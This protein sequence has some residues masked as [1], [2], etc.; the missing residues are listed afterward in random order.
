MNKPQPKLLKA[1]I[2]KDLMVYKDEFWLGMAMF[3]LSGRPV[4]RYPDSEVHPADLRTFTRTLS[5]REEDYF[6]DIQ[7]V[8]SD[9][10]VAL[11]ESFLL[12]AARFYNP[13][14]FPTI[15]TIECPVLR[16]LG[17]D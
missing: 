9:A 3:A 6:K 17:G 4:E 15:Q 16:M 2:H 12:S 5:A 13:E 10:I 1:R 14:K 11:I 7:E 8:Y